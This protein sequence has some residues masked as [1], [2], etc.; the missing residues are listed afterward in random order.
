M[1]SQRFLYRNVFQVILRLPPPPPH[2]FS[3]IVIPVKKLTFLHRK[4][5]PIA[6]KSCNLE[7]RKIS[8]FPLGLENLE[9][10]DGIFQSG[11]SQGILN[12]L[13]KSGKITRDTGK[14]R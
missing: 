6:M 4:P 9:K 3:L 2:R 5:W 8:G 10:W 13:E 14:L 1:R 11:K 12:R 7:L